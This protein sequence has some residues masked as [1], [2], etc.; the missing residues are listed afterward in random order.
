MVRVI[1][2]LPR[3]TVPMLGLRAMAFASAGVTSEAINAL[4]FP[5]NTKEAPRFKLTAPAFA[6]SSYVWEVTPAQQDGYYTTFFWVR[7]DDTFNAGTE[8]AGFHPYPVGGSGPVHNWEISAKGFDYVTDDNANDTTVVKG[9]KYIQ[10]ASIEIVGA[11]Y[12]VKYLWSLPDTNK[13][14]TYTFATSNYTPAPSPILIFGGNGW[15][16]TSE[17]LSGDLG[18]LKVF[19]AAL[20][21]AD[22]ASEGTNFSQTVTSAGGSN[23]YYGIKNWASNTDLTCDYSTGRSATWVDTGN[24]AT[25]VAA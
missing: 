20:S 12:V 6:P 1:P 13:I 2:S 16:S 7:G 5:S 17:N 24:K 9:V 15:A 11:N 18:R 21:V 3:G 22:L 14:I 25:L 10:A 19:S 8:Y 23:I 4:R